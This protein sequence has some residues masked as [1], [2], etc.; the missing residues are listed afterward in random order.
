MSDLVPEVEVTDS[1][2]R[3]VP[4]IARLTDTGLLTIGWDRKMQYLEGFENLP[5][6]KVA[7]EDYSLLSQ[8]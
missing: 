8:D 3:P 4:Y 5:R 1:E 7:I 2:E 6:T